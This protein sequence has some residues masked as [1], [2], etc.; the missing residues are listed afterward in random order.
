MV[1]YK[2][3]K[4]SYVIGGVAIVIVIEIPVLAAK[5]RS[6]RNLPAQCVSR[7]MRRA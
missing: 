2:L 5:Q 3:E 1:D 6:R 4:R 7:T